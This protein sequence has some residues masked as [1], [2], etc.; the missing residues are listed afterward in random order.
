MWNVTNFMTDE[1]WNFFRGMLLNEHPG[2]FG[3]LPKKGVNFPWGMWL[4]KNYCMV[5]ILLSFLCNYDNVTLNYIRKNVA[6]QMKDGFLLADAKL[7]LYQEWVKHPKKVSK[8][9][10]SKTKYH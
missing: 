2:N 7:A 9:I 1:V 10:T 4:H 6:T 3:G 8:S 5:V